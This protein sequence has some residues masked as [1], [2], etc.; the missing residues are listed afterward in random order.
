[1]DG[2]TIGG[3]YEL[4]EVV[5]SGGM[6]TVWR[7]RDVLLERKVALKIL[8]ARYGE[9]AEYVERFLREAAGS[10]S[11]VAPEHRHGHRPRR[12]T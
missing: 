2:E 10:R 3:R 8:H 12:G 7:A 11:D 9:D 6:S 5:G 4:E 1:M